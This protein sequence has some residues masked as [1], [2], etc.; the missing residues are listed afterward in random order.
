MKA[1]GSATPCPVCGT[2]IEH[3]QKRSPRAVN[4]P[5]CGELVAVRQ[6]TK[7]PTVPVPTAQRPV[8][9]RPTPSP[10]PQNT[11]GETAIYTDT[12][13]EVTTKRIVTGGITYSLR[14]VTSVH[15]GN[16]VATKSS[17]G[18]ALGIVFGL[19]FVLASIP[20]FQAAGTTIGLLT[21]GFGV[22]LIGV[23]TWSLARYEPEV[24]HH[25]VLVTNAGQ[26]HAY[27]S[28]SEQYVN[29]IVDAIS[30]AMAHD[31]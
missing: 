5:E 26:V 18:E 11:G 8:R 2:Q 28:K 30:D 12:N 4:C 14:N 10:K 29:K 15:A 23:A 13:F 24:S 1:A 17:V 16:T 9:R 19:G 3:S 27:T 20:T 21:L 7:P 22:G 6:Q 31:E 25:V